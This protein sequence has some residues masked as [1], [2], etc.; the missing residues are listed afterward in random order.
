[1]NKGQA[2]VVGLMVIVVI[3]LVIGLIYLRF[4]LIREESA[5]PDLRTNI[6]VNNLLRALV[7]LK[8]GNLTMSE[9]LYDCYNG[10]NCEMLKNRINDIL[11]IVLMP[12]EGFKFS[13]LAE[14][15]EII[16]FGNCNTG[17]LG[18]FPFVKNGISLET[19]MVLCKKQL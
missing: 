7:K 15:R 12:S 19:R 5:Y 8:I 16:S 17:I 4:A 2:E 13:L 9:S 14:E 1:M 11:D 18:S 3:L 10:L 6:Q